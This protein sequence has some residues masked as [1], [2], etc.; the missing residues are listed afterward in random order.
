MEESKGGK[1]RHSAG[2]RQRFRHLRSSGAYRSRRTPIIERRG[3]GGKGRAPLLLLLFSWLTAAGSWGRRRKSNGSH[4]DSSLKT[5]RT[6][7]GEER[8]VK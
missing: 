8:D 2:S 1:S 6:G 5:G 4:I 3:E 7:N